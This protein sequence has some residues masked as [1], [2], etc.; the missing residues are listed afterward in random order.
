MNDRE[1]RVRLL[2][3]S[4]V[5]R[6]PQFGCHPCENTTTLKFSTSDLMEKII[7]AMGHDPV[8]VDLPREEPC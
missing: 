6:E 1:N 4:E 5:L 2:I 8:I 7:P 3:D